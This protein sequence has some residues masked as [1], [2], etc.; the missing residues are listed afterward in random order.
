MVFNTFS[1]LMTLLL[2][3][4]HMLD[5]ST[6]DFW[7]SFSS[8]CKLQKSVWLTYHTQKKT[9]LEDIGGQFIDFE[10]N[11]VT[12]NFGKGRTWAAPGPCQQGLEGSVVR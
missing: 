5:T 3:V 6:A 11:A 9:Y 2:S 10:G 8:P 7:M 12:A 4:G 1:G